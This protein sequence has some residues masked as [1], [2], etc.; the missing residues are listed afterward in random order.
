M[1]MKRSQLERIVKEELLKHLSEQLTEGEPKKAE[2]QDGDED[3]KSKEKDGGK[4]EK[5]KTEPQADVDNLTTKPKTTGK[6]AG[7]PGAEEGEPEEQELEAEP[8]DDELEADVAD[9]EAEEEEEDA[10]E[11]GQSDISD[12]ITGKT[13][14]SITMEPKSK[15]MP[16]AQEVNITFKE[17]TDTLKILITK[18]GSVKWYWRGLHNEL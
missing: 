4:G 9:P 11:D 3:K 14:Q 1:K 6:P 2:V 7:E 12:D 18:T 10:E 16:G 17:V 8:A 13:I 15:M 5:G